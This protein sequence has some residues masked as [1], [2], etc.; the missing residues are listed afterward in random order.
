MEDAGHCHHH[1]LL[2]PEFLGSPVSV[3][4]EVPAFYLF[5]LPR[6]SQPGGQI[7][8]SLWSLLNQRSTSRMLVPPWIVSLGEP[9]LPL[10]VSLAAAQR[11]FWTN[12]WTQ[13]G[14]ELAPHSFSPEN[15]N[16]G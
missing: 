16:F 12:I 11:P 9:P 13:N 10:R 3:A 15:L 5:L 1:R 2:T 7:S 8:F 6:P 4:T 14:S